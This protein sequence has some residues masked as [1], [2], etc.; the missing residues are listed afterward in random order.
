MVGYHSGDDVL[1]VLEMNRSVPHAFSWGDLLGDVQIFDT[2]RMVRK[3]DSWVMKSLLFCT[4]LPIV[5]CKE[6]VVRS[7]SSHGLTCYV[8]FEF[9][10][11]L[12]IKVFSNDHM[13]N[14]TYG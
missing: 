12:S 3:V 8:S 5:W 11:K 2:D 10:C 14:I 13:F 6:F 4:F 7:A 1:E 9:S